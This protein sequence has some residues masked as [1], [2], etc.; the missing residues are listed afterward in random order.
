M[1]DDA[2]KLLSQAF[3]MLLVVFEF[4]EMMTQPIHI[5]YKRHVVHPQH[6]VILHFHAPGRMLGFLRE[7]LFA[8]EVDLALF[9]LQILSSIRAAGRACLALPISIHE[10]GDVLSVSTSGAV[11]R[12]LWNAF[13]F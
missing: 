1:C 9:L 3:D 12:C 5:I 7:V 13:H 8:R 4:V 6:L 2:S 10:R 11:E